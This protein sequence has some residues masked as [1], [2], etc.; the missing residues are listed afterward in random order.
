MQSA[1]N[2]VQVAWNMCLG[3]G[4]SARILIDEVMQVIWVAVVTVVLTMPEYTF[5]VRE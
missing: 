5:S 2:M 1:V 4:V 3:K